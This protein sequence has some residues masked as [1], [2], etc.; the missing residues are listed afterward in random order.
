MLL[1]IYIVLLFRRWSYSL[2]QLFQS[3]CLF[4]SSFVEHCTAF[5][6]PNHMPTLAVFHHRELKRF[7]RAPSIKILNQSVSI[8]LCFMIISCAALT[9]LRNLI[10][11]SSVEPSYIASLGMPLLSAGYRRNL[12]TL[13]FEACVM[14]KLWNKECRCTGGT[15]YLVCWAWGT[16]QP[17]G[18]CWETWNLLPRNLCRRH[19]RISLN[20]AVLSQN[21]SCNFDWPK[22]S[23]IYMYLTK[24]M[25]FWMF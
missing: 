16:P 22:S 9:T 24:T 5:S 8:S 18:S 15:L 17:L 12:L 21:L 13:E 6:A 4:T 1:D 23:Y 2:W 20:S 25:C 19:S 10:W 7:L 3:K 14:V 11:A